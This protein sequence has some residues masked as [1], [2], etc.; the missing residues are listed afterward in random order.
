MY[1]RIKINIIVLILINRQFCKI[2]FSGYHLWSNQVSNSIYYIP[3]IVLSTLST[4]SHLTCQSQKKL[5][6]NSDENMP[7]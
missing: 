4:L 5:T 7:G 3:V 6:P 1:A 2:F